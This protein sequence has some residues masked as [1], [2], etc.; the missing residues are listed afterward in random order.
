M[1]YVLRTTGDPT[2][3]APALSRAIADVNKDISFTLTP[4]EQTIDAALTQE[5]MLAMLAG[6]FG[7]L[8]LL[9]AGVGLYGMMSLAMTRRRNELGVRMALGADTHRILTLV[10]RDVLIVTTAGLL[11]G[12]TGALASSHIIAS[13][14]FG[15][16][17]TDPTTCAAAAALLATVA[18]LAAYLPARRAARLD[19][20]VALREE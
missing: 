1:T 2:S 17:P 10:L 15:I 19:P 6:F 18:V 8:A 12:T 4:M 16:T 3:L 20:M 5:R 11:A 9:V 7:A 14:L 13:L